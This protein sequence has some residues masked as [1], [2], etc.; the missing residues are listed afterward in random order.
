SDTDFYRGTESFDYGT[1][2]EWYYGTYDFRDEV[3]GITGTSIDFVD[4]ESGT[5]TSTIL[6]YMASHNRVL[7][8]E[9]V[10]GNLYWV[11]DDFSSAQS[12]TFTVEFWWRVES[13]SGTTTYLYFYSGATQ[14]V[15]IF[16]TDA[17]AIWYYDLG[18]IQQTIS[19][20]GTLVSDVW[21]HMEIIFDTDADR[22]D[23]YLN[24]VLKQNDGEFRNVVANIDQFRI[25]L[26]HANVRQVYYDA[27]GYSWDTTSHGGYGYTVSWN[28]NPYD[29]EGFLKNDFPIFQLNY[30]TEIR[31]VNSIGSHNNVL[32]VYDNSATLA[33]NAYYSFD[34]TSDY[35][36]VEFWWR[37]DDATD[38]FYVYI[39]NALSVVLGLRLFTD[40]FQY[41]DGGWTNIGVVPADN[42]WYHIRI[43]FESTTGGYDGL[44]QYDWNVHINGIG[45]GDY[46]FANNVA[47]IAFLRFASHS[48]TTNHHNYFD[49][50]G[51]SW[52]DNYISDPY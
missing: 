22:F 19:G 36:T 50:I 25:G 7:E 4:I 40:Q 18:G 41:Y 49:A 39:Y 24:G 38:R 16:T 26:Y 43:D 47:S 20:V 3:V 44:A 28:I 34:P 13:I 46:D 35:G 1:A 37:T 17:G 27:F 14:S 6:S 45:Y 12:G 51:Y 8:L 10:G 48:T 2:P 52:D 42:T 33:L 23:F 29:L 31:V 9:N 21:Y 15:R 30:G 5:G 11:Y 32:D